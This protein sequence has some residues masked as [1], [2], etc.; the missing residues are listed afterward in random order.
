MVVIATSNNIPAE[1]SFLS[2]SAQTVRG[3]PW[4]PGRHF[5]R[6]LQQ[7]WIKVKNRRHR[8][9]RVLTNF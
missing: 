2:S 3:K 9:S 6:Y 1:R 7:H 5:L 8:V 4:N